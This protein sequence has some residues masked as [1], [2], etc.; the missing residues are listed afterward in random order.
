MKREDLRSQT[1]SFSEGQIRSYLLT[2]GWLEVDVLERLA[3]IWRRPEYELSEAE[4]LLPLAPD[5]RDFRDRMADFF[6]ALAEFEGRDIEVVLQAIRLSAIDLV[7]VQVR[8]DDV[9]D[10]TIPLDDGVLLN[11]R[12]RDLMTSAVL[13]T[14][15]KRRHFQGNRPPEAT[16][17]LAR[18]RLGQT[19]IGSYVVNVLAPVGVIA[20]AQ[21]ELEPVTLS[22]TVTSNLA[23][24]LKAL[25]DA[26]TKY[27]STR[28]PAVFDLAVE[29]G[30]SA[31]MCEALASFSGASRTRS[32]SLRLDPARGPSFDQSTSLSFEFEATDAQI[33]GEAAGYFR[34]NYV[35]PDQTICGMVKRLDRLP[36]AETG[37]VTITAP[38]I[39]GQDKNIAVELAGDAYNEA[40]HAHERKVAVECRGDV[41]VTPRSARLLN[42]SGFKVF[43]NGQLF[44][45]A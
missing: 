15:S 21:E 6:L 26:I 7:S 32:F 1:S 35:L 37:T 43:W 22:Q 30:A 13:S 27:K 5:L 2:T 20:S 41:H 38:L 42:P 9:Q 39:G 45:D 12:A 33:L 4:L 14:L 11:Q 36:G 31:N 24:A 18:L 8:H 40:I 44:N 17:Y 34:D 25:T 3:T 16:A 23:S 10:G 29:R 19:K 28:N